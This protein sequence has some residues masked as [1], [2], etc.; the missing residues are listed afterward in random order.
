MRKKILLPFPNG[1]N[2]DDLELIAQVMSNKIRRMNFPMSGGVI[3]DIEY[4]QTAETDGAS[5]RLGLIS[6]KLK[7]LLEGIFYT[8]NESMVLH[9]QH[10]H[11]LAV[12][13]I[14]VLVVSL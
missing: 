14:S 3:I 7:P 1:F 2:L 6:D 8:K 10:G 13:A 5:D 4:H 9:S 12:E 11:F